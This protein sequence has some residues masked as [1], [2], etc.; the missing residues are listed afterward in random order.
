MIINLNQQHFFIGST[1]QKAK[2]LHSWLALPK[3]PISLSSCTLLLVCSF[4]FLLTMIFIEDNGRFDSKKC[5]FILLLDPICWLICKTSSYARPKA[6]IKQLKVIQI[7]GEK[8]K[9][10]FLLSMHANCRA[11]EFPVNPKHK[12]DLPSV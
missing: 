4:I 12:Q 3:V 11:K 1:T 5:L 8:T 10:W 6:L 9:R 2:H 7:N